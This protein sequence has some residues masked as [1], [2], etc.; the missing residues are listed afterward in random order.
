MSCFHDSSVILCFLL[1]LKASFAFYTNLAK[2]IGLKRND[3][4]IIVKTKQNIK[5]EKSG[6][7][8]SKEI[9]TKKN[10]SV[11]SFPEFVNYLLQIPTAKDVSNQIN[12]F[13]VFFMNFTINI[14]PDSE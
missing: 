9:D 6:K 13:K 4:T 8:V 3:A 7:T 12:N 1:G 2:K 14:C 11:P 5:D 10:I